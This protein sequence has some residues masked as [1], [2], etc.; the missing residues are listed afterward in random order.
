[1][2]DAVNFAF[3][4]SNAVFLIAFGIV[5]EYNIYH[6]LRFGGPGENRTKKDGRVDC[7]EEF[8]QA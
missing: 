3:I 6:E 8:F 4:I 7:M 1:M 2:I 5:I